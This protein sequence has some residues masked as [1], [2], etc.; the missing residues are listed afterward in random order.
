[1]NSLLIPDNNRATIAVSDG[2][3]TQRIPAKLYKMM[4]RLASLQ[5][6]RYLLA[7]TV[8]DNVADWTILGTGK[9]EK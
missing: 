1:M 8:D 5:N 7:V 4:L 2:E 3:H 6:G 9:V